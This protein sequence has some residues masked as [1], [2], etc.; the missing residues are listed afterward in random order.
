MGPGR[1]KT[2]THRTRR[3][4]PAAVISRRYRA[5]VL[6][7]PSPFTTRPFPVPQLYF[8]Y[9]RVRF[10]PFEEAHPLVGRGQPTVIAEARK[11]RPGLGIRAADCPRQN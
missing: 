7:L 8:H 3:R 9:G 1:H 2:S 10:R 4:L 5:A 11:V 6:M